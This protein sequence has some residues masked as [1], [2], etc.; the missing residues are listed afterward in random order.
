MVD[1]AQLEA[2][3][4][5]SPLRITITQKKSKSDG[6]HAK[7][8]AKQG[9]GTATEITVVDENDPHKPTLER[10]AVAPQT[11]AGD[12]EDMFSRMHNACCYLRVK[13]SRLP[14]PRLTALSYAPEKIFTFLLR[15]D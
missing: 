7:S 13:S 3:V 5:A 8:E 15:A 12:I 11:N 4:L 1:S 9:G 6:E 2:L 14:L 10:V